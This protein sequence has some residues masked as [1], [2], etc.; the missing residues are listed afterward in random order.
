MAGEEE[1]YLKVEEAAK[2]LSVTEYT[3]RRWLRDKKIKGSRPGGTKAGW[4]IAESEI[5]R[6]LNG[7]EP[8][9]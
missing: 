3:V 2:R 8:G 4:R 6:V 9:A 1:R 5:R 7:E